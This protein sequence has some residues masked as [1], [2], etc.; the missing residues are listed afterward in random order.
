MRIALIAFGVLTL[1]AAA[2]VAI[3]VTGLSNDFLLLAFI[4]S[5]W[6][7]AFAFVAYRPTRASLLTMGACSMIPTPLIVWAYWESLYGE[8]TGSTSAL[9]WV[10]APMQQ[11]GV[12]AFGALWVLFRESR[13]QR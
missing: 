1:A 7:G 12:L 6:G 13:A 3:L 10:A 8:A 9:V 11:W 5:P 2:V 4:V